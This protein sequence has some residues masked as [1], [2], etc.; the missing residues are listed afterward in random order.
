MGCRSALLLP[1]FYYKNPSD[2]GLLAYFDE[3]IQRVGGD[4]RLYLYNFP[5]QSAVPFTV[6]FIARLLRAYPGKVKGIKDS[7][8]SY[9]NGIAYAT[10]FAA[11]GFEV[12]AGDDTLLK[13]LLEKGAAGCLTAASNVNSSIGGRS[14]RAGTRPPAPRLT[15]S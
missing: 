8:G 6:D 7:S 4:I 3:V 5:Q 9:E 1:P 2:D 14:T 11:D 15:R 13:P 12:Y 10:N